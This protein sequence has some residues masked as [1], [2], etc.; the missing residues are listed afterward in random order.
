MKYLLQFVSYALFA[1]V[2]GLFSIWP[3]YA[4]LQQ[5][6]A[7]ISLTFSHAAELI[8]ECRRLSQ[9]ELNELP[10]NMRKPDECPRERHPLILQFGIDGE[11]V[12]EAN[13]PPSGLWRDG[14]TD[15]YRRLRVGAGEHTLFIGMRDSGRTTGFDYQ[16]DFQLSIGPGQ[17]I[18][19]G[20][21][22]SAGQFQTHQGS[23]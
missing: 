8:G 17:N 3:R 21:D 4:L 14:K 7:I 18:A 16:R 2:V 12:Y 9:E 15:V 5:D 1:V 23:R 6:E 19:I 10:P 22:E 11:T 13:L 20:F